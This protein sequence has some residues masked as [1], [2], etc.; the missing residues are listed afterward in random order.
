MVNDYI[1]MGNGEFVVEIRV[2]DRLDGTSLS[3]LFQNGSD[4]VP[5]VLLVKHRSLSIVHSPEDHVLYA[6]DILVL[7]GTLESL[8]AFAPKLA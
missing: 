1:P 6:K 5:Q 3:R 8:R 4:D 2:S 7:F